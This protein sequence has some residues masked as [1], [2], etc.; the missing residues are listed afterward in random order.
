MGNLTT[1]FVIVVMINLFLFFGQS[2]ILEINPSSNIFFNNTDTLLDTYSTEAG[3][4]N[5]TN[6]EDRIN[7]N[8]Q[9]VTSGDTTNIFTDSINAVKSWF[10]G[11]S[12]IGYVLG[13][14]SAP[15]NFLKALRL[16]DIFVSGIGTAWYILTIFLLINFIKGG[17]GE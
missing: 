3:T 14:V 1:A 11:V 10:L 8:Q 6:I 7:I 4:L 12:G 13:V 17:G 9:S 16:P 2:A 15:Y 5:D